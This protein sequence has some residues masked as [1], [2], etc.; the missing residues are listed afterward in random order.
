VWEPAS[1][2]ELG[3]LARQAMLKRME[4]AASVQQSFREVAL[5]EVTP[6]EVHAPRDSVREEVARQPDA[7]TPPQRPSSDPAANIH[8]RPFEVTDLFPH[9]RILK[10]RRAAPT[11]APRH[12]PLRSSDVP[13]GSQNVALIEVQRELNAIRAEISNLSRTL[14]RPEIVR[15]LP[16][17]VPQGEVRRIDEER[18]DAAAADRAEFQARADALEARRRQEARDVEFIVRKN[19]IERINRRQEDLLMALRRAESRLNQA[20]DDLPPGVRDG[21]IGEIY[22]ARHSIAMFGGS[23]GSAQ[24]SGLAFDRAA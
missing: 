1:V 8:E 17:G 20:K 18:E 7:P 21:I 11:D 24:L 10:D 13:P 3:L 2:G 19:E 5:Q 16:R 6:R 4:G 12:D 23:M 22:R 9:Q 14:G 15:D